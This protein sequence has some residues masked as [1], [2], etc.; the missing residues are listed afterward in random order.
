MRRPSQPHSALEQELAML[1]QTQKQ[2]EEGYPTMYGQEYE[3]TRE[4]RNRVRTIKNR[5][6]AK[7][8]RDQARTHVQKL[9]SG[10]SEMSSRNDALA[11]KLEIAEADN[12]KLRDEV[13]RLR[14]RVTEL[15]R[16]A[17]PCTDA[18]TLVN[19]G[20]DVSAKTNGAYPIHLAAIYGCPSTSNVPSGVCDGRDRIMQVSSGCDEKARSNIMNMDKR[21]IDQVQTFDQNIA[22]ASASSDHLVTVKSEKRKRQNR[23]AQRRHRERQL[24]LQGRD[25]QSNVEY[26]WAAYRNDLN[27][28]HF[29]MQAASEFQENPEDVD[30]QTTQ[31]NDQE[32][33]NYS[34]EDVFEPNINKMA[35]D[36]NSF[37]ESLS[38]KGSLGSLMLSRRPSEEIKEVDMLLQANI[39]YIEPI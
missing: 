33:S 35:F 1:L 39:Q 8:S 26:D 37:P 18:R 30:S 13:A 10:I 16:N 2:V 9:E 7:K 12:L 23:D 31:E 27:T 38:R 32:S 36:P 14:Q 34:S 20:T 21:S 25:L 17:S 29:A 22:M 24:S 4:I 11:K 5:L 6:A 28:M 3:M 15:E 19:Y